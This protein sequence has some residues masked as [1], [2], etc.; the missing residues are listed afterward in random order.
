MVHLFY[1]LP[2]LNNQTA[3]PS[4]ARL[5]SANG[6]QMSENVR[7]GHPY[8]R[9]PALQTGFIAGFPPLG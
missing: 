2:Y 1:I 7:S 8:V 3:P 9:P 4:T 6:R 5:V